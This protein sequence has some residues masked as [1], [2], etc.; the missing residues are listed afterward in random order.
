M[1]HMLSHLIPSCPSRFVH[2]C[3]HLR[4]TPAS[5]SFRLAVLV[6]RASCRARAQDASSRASSR[7]CAGAPGCPTHLSAASRE[8]TAGHAGA[9]WRDGT[10]GRCAGRR[11]RRQR[12]LGPTTS[13]RLLVHLCSPSATSCACF[14]TPVGRKGVQGKYYQHDDWG[15]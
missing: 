6:V 12:R 7:V 4:S 14:G 11:T 5:S 3:E 1:M 10:I 15:Q 13:I 9:A 2:R 8:K